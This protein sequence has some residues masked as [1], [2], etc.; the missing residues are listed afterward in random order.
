ML[1]DMNA[2]LALHF[3]AADLPPDVAPSA[4]AAGRRGP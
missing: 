4:L 2:T 1:A 3:G